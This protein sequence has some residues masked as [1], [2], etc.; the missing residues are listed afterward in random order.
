M[1]LILIAYRTQTAYPVIL[2]ANRDEFFARPTASCRYWSE[3]PEI[4]AGKDLQAGG[5]WL[6]VNRLGKL[7][8]LTNYRQGTQHNTQSRSRGQ[9][10]L[11]FLNH[12]QTAAEYLQNCVAQAVNYQGFNLILGDL[13]Q[14]YYYS[15]RTKT[16]PI[17]L[18]AGIYGLS[19]HLL[20]TPWDKVLRAKQIFSE[21]LTQPFEVESYFSLLRNRQQ[22]PD[23][24][25]PD[26]GV[27]TEWEKLL[28]SIFIQSPDYG[29]R[30]SSVL[31]M[32]ALGE[33]EFWERSFNAAGAE[34]TLYYQFHLTAI[35]LSVKQYD[36]RV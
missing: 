31:R 25:L 23:H 22:T 26:T 29:T 10:V 17:P 14:L 5:T 1:C 7:A 28:S 24:A 21:L 30:C 34:D 36:M 9:L 15:N 3:Y 12:Q 11:D 4:L 35:K 32:S 13:Q 27:S 20:D 16:A 8:A 2:V 18:T 33:I 19:N 6:G